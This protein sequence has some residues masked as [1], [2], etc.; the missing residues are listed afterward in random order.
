METPTTRSGQVRETTSRR[1]PK[2][3]GRA[4]GTAMAGCRPAVAPL[5]GTRRSR[6]NDRSHRAG[7]VRA[8]ETGRC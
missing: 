3:A 2:A 1:L 5:A 8:A 4:V 6:R 7:S